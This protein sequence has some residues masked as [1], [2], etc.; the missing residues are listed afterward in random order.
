MKL[1]IDRHPEADEFAF[2]RVLQYGEDGFPKLTDIIDPDELE[3]D[4]MHLNIAGEGVHVWFK[5]NRQ[6]NGACWSWT[7]P[8]TAPTVSPSIEVPGVLHGHL[9]SG[10]WK[11]V[12]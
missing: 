7:G 1:A 2:V 8:K 11:A 12:G 3:P 5:P 9:V 6:P 10:Q 4:G